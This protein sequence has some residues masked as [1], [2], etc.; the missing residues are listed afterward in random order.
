MILVTGGAYQGKLAFAMSLPGRE[1]QVFADGALCAEADIL[2]DGA[3]NA[4]HLYVKRCL[5]EGQDCAGIMDRIAEE[6]PDLLVIT[7]E[8]GSGI[9][10]ADPFERRWREEAGRLA[11]RIAA[12]AE[13]V[14]RVTCGIG[15]RIK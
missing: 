3:V 10:P 12:R 7:D 15:V 4:L 8:V 2:R 1:G 13:A 5:R 6:V 14:Y 11:C 9:V